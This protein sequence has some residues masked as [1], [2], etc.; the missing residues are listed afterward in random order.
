[1]MKY[2]LKKM[3]R[4]D[5]EDALEATTWSIKTMNDN[6]TL[7]FFPQTDFF[8]CHTIIR[9]NY[10]FPRDVSKENAHAI[11]TNSIANIWME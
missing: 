1:M 8:S 11:P 2:G 4:K 10:V 7:R 6:I 3:T 9:S 5:F